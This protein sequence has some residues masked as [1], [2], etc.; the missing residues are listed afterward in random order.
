MTEQ[1]SFN[2]RHLIFDIHYLKVI[3]LYAAYGQID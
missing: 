1:V 2:I 3:Y